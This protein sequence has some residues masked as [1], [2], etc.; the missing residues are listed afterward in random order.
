[1]YREDSATKGENWLETGR[2]KAWQ[3]R[4]KTGKEAGRREGRKA[5]RQAGR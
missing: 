1:M 2:P 3:P 4:G 5:G